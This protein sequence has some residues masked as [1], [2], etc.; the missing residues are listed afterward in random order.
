MNNSCITRIYSYICIINYNLAT[1]IS[2]SKNLNDEKVNK[3]RGGD[4]EFLLGKRSNVCERVKRI[5]F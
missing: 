3:K 2:K 5:L 1:C 4:N